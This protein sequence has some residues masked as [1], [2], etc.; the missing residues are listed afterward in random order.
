[1]NAV[2]R[3][4]MNDKSSGSNIPNYLCL[5]AL[6]T[7]TFTFTYG[8]GVGIG[9][10]NATSISYSTDG[11]NWTKLDNVANQTVSITTPTIAAG[12]KVYW[13]GVNGRISIGASANQYSCFSSTGDFDVNGDIGS[14]LFDDNFEERIPTVSLLYILHSLFRNSKVRDASELKL[15]NN[16]GSSFVANNA[17]YIYGYMFSGCSNLIA[18]PI[19]PNTFVGNNAYEYMFDGCSALTT[20]PD[21]PKTQLAGSIYKYMFQNCT[22]LTTIPE[23]PATTLYEDCYSGMFKGCTGLIQLPVNYELPATSLTKNCYLDMFCNC[24]NLVNAPKL[25]A[26][27][28][29]YN[30]YAEMFYNCNALTNVPDIYLSSVTAYSCRAMFRGCT[31]LTNNPIKQFASNT[32]NY[33][34]QFMFDGTKITEL[35]ELTASTLSAGAYW[36]MLSGVATVTWIKILALDVSA[37]YSNAMSP[38]NRN[39]VYVKHIDA[40]WTS[41]TPSKWTVIYYDPTVDKYYTD[42]TRSQECDDHGNPI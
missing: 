40:T 9:S 38:S 28:I 21:L 31:S 12:G 23:L 6:E 41:N 18:A 25:P 8:S 36:N 33:C 17:R 11:V 10:S 2:R 32:G 39:G 4:L 22:S 15:F 3:S 24:S 29:A 42:Q 13:K 1:M 30:S 34:Y 5:T 37:S 35:P 20:P 27:S 16:T 26:T 7:G 14:I 19:I